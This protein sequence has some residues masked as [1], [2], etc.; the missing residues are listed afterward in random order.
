MALL[1][2]VWAEVDADAVTVLGL[3]A[4][5]AVRVSVAALVHGRAALVLGAQRMAAAALASRRCHGEVLWAAS[6]VLLLAPDAAVRRPLSA[7]VV[8]GAA[9]VRWAGGHTL[10]AVAVGPSHGEACIGAVAKLEL[11]AL[12]AV[13]VL[14]SASPVSGAAHALRAHG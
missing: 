9:V 5:A 11:A 10:T 2:A 8:G 6:S 13:G 14:S 12:P 4:G 7:V 3:A 1:V